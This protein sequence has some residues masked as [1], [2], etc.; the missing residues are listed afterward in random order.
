[1]K[2]DFVER[3]SPDYA[4]VADHLRLSGERNRWANRG[5]LYE[6]V[7][8]QFASHCDLH[9]DLRFVPVATHLSLRPA[10]LA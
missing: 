7:Q 1:M 6:L 2:V 3:K 9:G 10:R 5:P 8:Q 4:R